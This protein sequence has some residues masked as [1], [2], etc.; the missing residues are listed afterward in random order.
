MP[1]A[2]TIGS[3]LA[4][5]PLKPYII[6]EIGVNHEGSMELAKRL[7]DEAAEGGAHAA[8]FQSY[9]AGKIASKNSPAYWDQSKEPTDSQFKLFQKYDGFNEQEYIE[10]AEHCRLRGI[11]FMSTPFDLDAV[12][13]L[14]PLMSAFKIA[15][16]DITNVPL[17]RKCAA[18][19]KPMIISTGASSLP[20]IEF[21]LQT[22]RSAGAKE[23]ALL[24]CVLNYPT[25]EENAA[26]FEIEV[27]ARTFPDC[28]IGYSDH[29]VPDETISALE[30]AVL[31]GSCILEK[32]F[33]H[34]KSLPGNDHYHAMDKEDLKL[35]VGKLKTYG[36][37]LKDGCE[38]KDL[39]KESAAR[40]HARRSIVANVKIK[41][42]EML[43]EDNLIAKRPGHGISPV[44]WDE[45]I[46]KT[47]RLDIE[48]DALIE[49]Q[50]L[51]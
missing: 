19:G 27:L 42:G 8:K 3:F 38:G 21:A 50:M 36:R 17:I 23:I 43:S 4:E 49:W 2:F 29:V 48:E 28:T 9:K 14:N 25:P 39:K 20:E 5:N 44:H 22:A 15:S 16:A 33:T 34:D 31:K 45:L 12:D 18:Q 35:F 47:V 13:F 51:D 37:L 40:L 24:H 46:G 41:A 30:V 26:L 1:N 10:L 6:A 11:D 32:H 7:I